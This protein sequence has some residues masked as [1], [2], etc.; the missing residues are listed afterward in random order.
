MAGHPSF[1]KT[2]AVTATRARDSAIASMAVA[3][4][5]GGLLSPIALGITQS[6]LGQGWVFIVASSLVGGAIMC[7]MGSL[8][9]KR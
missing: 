1:L 9:V 8:I 2:Y 4:S 7:L 5:V 6:I 3:E